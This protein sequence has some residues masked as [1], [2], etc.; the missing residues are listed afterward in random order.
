MTKWTTRSLNCATYMTLRTGDVAEVVVS[1]D[2]RNK[3]QF[4]MNKPLEVARDDYYIAQSR[5]TALIGDI[6]KY[7]RCIKAYKDECKRV[8]ENYTGGN[9]NGK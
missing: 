8:N 5:N 3:F 7:N 1:H 2:G 6:R 4:N 9:K